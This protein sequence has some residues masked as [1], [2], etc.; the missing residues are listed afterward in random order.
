[1]SFDGKID[2]THPETATIVRNFGGMKPKTNL[3]P[4]AL[5]ADVAYGTKTLKADDL[6]VKLGSAGTLQGKINILP[7]GEGRSINVDLKADKLALAALTGDSTETSSKQVEANTT[8][9]NEDW[10]REAIDLSS[11]RGLK[12]E[13]HVVIGELLYK[14]FVIN[15]F[16][17]GLTFANNTVKVDQFSGQLFDAGKFSI[18]GQLA[19]GAKGQA[20]RGDFAITIDNTD[21]KKLFEALGSKPFTQGIVD[22]DQKIV[23]NGASQYD[24]VRSLD[25]DGTLKVT[26]GIV[27]GIDLDA[28]GAKLDRPNSLSD[29]AA[30]IDQTRAGGQTKIGNLN[31]PVKIRDGVVSLDNVTIKT[32]KTAMAM[33]GNV[34]LPTKTIDA[35][36]T[37]Q[38]VEQRNLPPLTMALTGPM[39]SPSKNFDTRSFTTFYAQ[40]AAEKYTAK[41]TEKVQNKL[42][43]LLG[44]PEQQAAPAAVTPAV[45]TPA[46]ETTPTAPAETAP[47]SGTETTAPIAEPVA[48]TP[49]TAPTAGS[50][51]PA[52]QQPQSNDDAL[53]QLG[54]QLL[55]DF[56]SG[57]QQQ[58][59]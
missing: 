43:N 30:I 41:A 38:F 8:I 16:K 54:G 3:G 4:F 29:F 13:A 21:A 15:D 20:H 26:D 49:P 23:F 51:Q 48:P 9:K 39:G 47:A 44:I 46:A 31:T 58:A 12:G 56:L 32:E 25:G 18:N 57:N 2:V 52:Q 33:Q 17:T 24:I 35:R 5:K 1:M 11:L 55:N 53:K 6:L 40:K 59:Q 28:L 14:K 19:P 50:E 37:I 36:G 22:L 42:N 27:N 45:E 10:P 34:N 7:Q